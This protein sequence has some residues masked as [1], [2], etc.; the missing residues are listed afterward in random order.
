MLWKTSS[1]LMVRWMQFDI[2]WAQLNPVVGR[3]QA[4]HRPV[5]VISNDIENSM[6]IVTVIPIT[7]KKK[8]RKI[9]PNELLFDLG[10]RESILLMHQIRTISK[11]RLGKKIDTLK[12]TLR[13]K[14]IEI[15][16][17]RF[18]SWQ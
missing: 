2:Y 5:M 15:L 13:K 17:M 14:V 10:N 8:G 4:G 12:A 9:Y 11:H 3:E 7:S 1:M 6:D 18:E 16:C